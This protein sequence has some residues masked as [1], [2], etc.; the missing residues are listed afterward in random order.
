MSVS[1]LSS[2][3]T[4]PRGLDRD[5]VLVLSGGAARGSIQAGMLRA[6]VEAGVRPT[7]VVGTSVGAL[8]AAFLAQD[9][10]LA[11]AMRLCDIWQKVDFVDVFGAQPW[12]APL[13][14]WANGSL[15]DGAALKA[16]IERLIP[17]S[18]ADLQVE[19]RIVAADLHR[20]AAR[21]FSRGRLR[22][23]VRAS[24]SIPLVFPPVTLSM[25]DP[26]LEGR[27]AGMLV[28]GGLMG[29]VPLSEAARLNPRAILIGDVGEI[30]IPEPMPTRGL[31]YAQHLVQ[32]LRRAPTRAQVELLAE[33]MPLVFLPAPGA[34]SVA[35]H[36]FSQSEARMN[37][38][39]EATRALL[40][41]GDFESCGL[42]GEL[43]PVADVD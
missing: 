11:G 42:T 22:D 25:D 27:P 33:Q 29:Q 37:A 28:D 2:V 15:S 17:A 8:N 6:L 19:L 40:L 32:M 36:D 20:G 7:H 10:S 35:L 43:I 24:A 16:L 34:A 21:V 14:Y 26:G 12:W 5:V 38:A 23:H 1:P 4:P 41:A 18:Y 9:W 31:A 3:S 13:R 30:A 39:Y